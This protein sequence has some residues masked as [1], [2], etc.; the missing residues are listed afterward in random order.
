MSIPPRRIKTWEELSLSDNFIFQKVMRRKRLCKR[1]IEKILAIKIR[2]ITFSE[3]EKSISVRR[4]S[5]S[6]RLDVYVEDENGTLYDIE[7]QTTDSA[8]PSELPKRTRY[9][10]A[11]MDMDILDKG[12]YYTELR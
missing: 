9:Y 7:M 1:L 6:V 4:D 3:T 8:S 11:M 12:A 5:K 2:R 10:Q